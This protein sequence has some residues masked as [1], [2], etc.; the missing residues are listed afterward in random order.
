MVSRM[1]RVASPAVATS[2][3]RPN[4]DYCRQYLWA[5]AFDWNAGIFAW[6]SDVLL[7][8]PAE[9]APDIAG[10]LRAGTDPN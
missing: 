5:G 3:E 8:E 1:T 9:H 10:P 6:R 4:A 2:A 7:D